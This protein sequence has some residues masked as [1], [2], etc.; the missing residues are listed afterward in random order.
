METI[1]RIPVIG[2]VLR[3]LLGVIKLPKHLDTLYQITQS[4]QKKEQILQQE[5]AALKQEQAA[6]KQGQAA[7]KQGQD[8]FQQEQDASI[9]ELRGWNSDRMKDIRRVDGRINK[10][11]QEQD[12][13]IEE[14]RSWNSD[15]MEEIR[16]V[17]GRI[18]NP[19]YVKRLNLL[20]SIQP[21][22]WGS[23]DRLHISDLASVKACMFNTNSGD[24]TI[25]DYTFAGSGVS[26]L[27]GSHDMRLTGLLRRDAE[28]TEG[29][30]IVIGNGVWLASNCTILGPASIGDNAVVAA[31]AVVTPGTV[32]PANMIYGGVPA[33]NI[34]ELDTSGEQDMSNPAVICA[35]ERNHG[36][37][38]I[39][40]W[41]EKRNLLYE[42]EIYVGHIQTKETAQIYL[43]KNKYKILYQFKNAEECI[44]SIKINNGDEVCHPLLESE[45]ILELCVDED[46]KSVPK[47]WNILSMRR[48]TKEAELF[49][50][51]LED[52]GNRG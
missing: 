45:G 51:I 28:L 25:G 21:T 37:L 50:S 35:L 5:Q 3:I 4:V 8:A 9:E 7:L 43:A 19:D 34:G 36:V 15:R 40:G 47:M 30:D 16:R 27:A 13:A 2:Y 23:E 14:L 18:D 46:M 17:D 39:D 26:I 20:L 6:L 32:I 11:Q 22:L 48:K 1:K 24:I 41:T 49:I 42:D 29:C 12:A 44:I 52:G 10:F 38:Y 31:G 33:R